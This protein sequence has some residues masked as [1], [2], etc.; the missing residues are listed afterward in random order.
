M[1][2]TFQDAVIVTRNVGV[3]YLWIDSLC[4]YQDDLTDWASEAANMAA[5]YSNAFLVIAASSASNGDVG[6]FTNRKQ[7]PCVKVE[8]T[9]LGGRVIRPEIFVRERFEHIDFD[10]NHPQTNIKLEPLLDRAWA[11]QERWLATRIL[12]YASNEMVWECRSSMHCECGGYEQEKD[13]RSIRDPSNSIYSDFD[14]M[15]PVAEWFLIVKNYTARKLRRQSDKLVALAGIAR[16]LR[17]PDLGRYLAGI[18]EVAFVRSLLWS[19][20]WHERIGIRGAFVAPSWSWASVS[21]PVQYSRAQ[22]LNDPVDAE[23]VEV[24]CEL[25]SPDEHGQV[26]G[27]YAVLKA[28][29]MNLQLLSNGVESEDEDGH[30]GRITS[31][32]VGDMDGVPLADVWLDVDLYQGR[33]YCSDGQVLVGA[34]IMID[35][36][37]AGKCFALILRPLKPQ[38]RQSKMKDRSNAF[39]RIG[40]TMGA[41]VFMFEDKKETITIV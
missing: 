9:S 23:V 34:C 32:L 37:D 14:P 36:L 5:V 29:L 17:K 6:C 41:H 27:G 33:D 38:E 8:S 39:V 4:I 20:V 3:R 22:N 25:R 19:A 10:P 18:W 12:H 13:N 7:M 16:Q 24:D 21:C 28:R 31:P 26:T 1:P 11:F 35:P 15:K 40:M 2:R 30:T